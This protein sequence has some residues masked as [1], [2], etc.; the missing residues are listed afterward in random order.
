MSS[1]VRLDPVS[2]S[3]SDNA[4]PLQSAKLLI[5]TAELARITSL[6]IR[7]LRRMDG[8]RDIPGRVVVRR[9]VRF[10]TEIIK[11]WVRAGLPGREEWA[12]QQKR[13]PSARRKE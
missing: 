10:Q 13:N 6:S 1:D 2:H 3:I 8:V 11:E 12:A 4:T 5:D 7:T 9:C